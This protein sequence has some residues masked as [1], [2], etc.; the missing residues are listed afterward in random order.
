MEPELELANI[1][2]TE[3]E[4]MPRANGVAK[5][6]P[7]VARLPEAEAQV[8]A[9]VIR[10]T[11]TPEEITKKSAIARRL[12]LDVFRAT[13]VGA[14]KIHTEL[15]AGI[16][17]IGRELDGAERELR[18]R[19]EKWEAEL[20][21]IETHAA[22]MEQHRRDNLRTARAA[23]I[24]PFLT[25]PLT[26]DL[27]DLTEEQFSAQLADARDLHEMREAKRIKEEEERKAEEAAKEAERLRVE[28][29]KEA[30]RVRLAEEN[31][32]LEAE[33]KAERE[34]AEAERARL[35]E[36]AR[37]A[38]AERKRLANEAAAAAA[39]KAK[40][41]AEAA[42]AKR[43]AAS[44]PDAAKIAA[45]AE[46]IAALVPEFSSPFIAESVACAIGLATA[47]LAR[48]RERLE[49]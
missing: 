37:K 46:S 34:A 5:F 7:L 23:E 31:R 21:A 12:R 29:E 19:C 2:D 39:A 6:A 3:I 41:E 38:E 35:A 26:V 40:E 43:R 30:E 44:A 13:R 24:T 45:L 15:K 32:R 8:E 36:E 4:V 47:E 49:S 28:A 25:G 14:K 33:R 17:E 27:A 10:A 22:R 48:I 18:Q 16:L 42:A 9:L 20:E 1:S 11:D